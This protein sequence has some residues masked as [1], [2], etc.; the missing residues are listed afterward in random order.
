MDFA[1]IVAGAF[2]QLFLLREKPTTWYQ[3]AIH[4]H[5][6]ID[7]VIKNMN[8]FVLVVCGAVQM[9]DAYNKIMTKHKKINKWIEPNDGTNQ[10]KIYYKQ[11]H[12][13]SK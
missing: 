2:S 7:L 5:T 10:N 6:T 9:G 13:E 12:A 3:F 4:I 8:E 1:K 11:S